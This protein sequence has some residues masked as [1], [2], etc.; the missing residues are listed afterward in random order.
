MTRP[1][2]VEI[3][4]GTMFVPKPEYGEGIDVI[5]DIGE[6]TTFESFTLFED[7]EGKYLYLSGGTGGANIFGEKIGQMTPEEVIEA[8]SQGYRRM[9]RELS[10]KHM[11]LLQEGAKKGSRILLLRQ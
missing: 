8:F 11:S 10:A 9:G 4:F 5:T 7:A 1:E 2:S 6:S 3:S